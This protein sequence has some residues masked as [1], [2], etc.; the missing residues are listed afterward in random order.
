MG[1]PAN[2][3]KVLKIQC[4]EQELKSAPVLVRMLAKQL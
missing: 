2:V 1:E 3:A 4:M